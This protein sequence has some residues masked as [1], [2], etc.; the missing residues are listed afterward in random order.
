MCRHCS[1]WPLLRSA[2]LNTQGFPVCILP[3][4]VLLQL[5][6]Q[7]LHCH[8]VMAL[9]SNSPHSHGAARQHDHMHSKEKKE[10]YVPSFFVWSFLLFLSFLLKLSEQIQVRPYWSITGCSCTGTEK[11]VCWV[12]MTLIMWPPNFSSVY[13]IYL[14]FDGWPGSELLRADSY[15]AGGDVWSC[16]TCS[17]IN[18]QLR[19]ACECWPRSYSLSPLPSI[20]WDIDQL[21]MKSFKTPTLLHK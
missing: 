10:Q 6:E 21:Y 1:D 11:T 19:S 16:D 12:V 5:P 15:E 13:V 18:L 14:C 7:K 4:Q 2:P 20:A 17:Y 3:F 9:H 8:L